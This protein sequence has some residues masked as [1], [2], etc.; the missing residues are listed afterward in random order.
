MTTASQIESEAPG[1][2]TLWTIPVI[3]KN[4]NA[5]RMNALLD[6]ASTKTYLNSDIPAQLGLQGQC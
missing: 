5:N 1:F 4:G 3:L 6:D 2:V